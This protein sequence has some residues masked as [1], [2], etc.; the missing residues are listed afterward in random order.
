MQVTYSWIVQT[1]VIYVNTYFY[2]SVWIRVD[3]CG[4]ETANNEANRVKG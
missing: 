3:V 4:R 1:N 2:V